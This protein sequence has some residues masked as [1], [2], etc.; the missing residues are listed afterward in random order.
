MGRRNKPWIR[1]QDGQWWTTFRGKKTALRV[2]GE[3]NEAE[4]WKVFHRLLEGILP[5]KQPLRT[6]P[7]PVPKPTSPFVVVN[8]VI[9]ATTLR[10]DDTLPPPVTVRDVIDAYLRDA[11][12]RVK[13]DTLRTYRGFLDP[14]AAKWGHLPAAELTPKHLDA[15]ADGPK[16]W[17]RPWSHDTRRAFKLQVFS[18]Y[19]L[20][21]RTRLL[22]RS[23][24][25]GVKVPGGR[26]RGADAVYTDAEFEKL[27]D[28]AGPH[29]RPLLEFLWLTGCRPGEASRIDA[30]DVV[31]EASV[32][33]V[34]EH[35]TKHKGKTRS[36]PLHPDALSLLRRLAERSPTGPLLRNRDGMPWNK[37]ALVLAMRRCRDR[38]GL[39]TKQMYGIR[40]SFAT[41]ALIDGVENAKVAAILGHSSTVMLSKHYS[42][43]AEQTRALVE[44]V[45][46]VRQ[47]KTPDRGAGVSEGQGDAIPVYVALPQ[48]T[49]PL[50]T[51]ALPPTL[52]DHFTGA[53][54][55][56]GSGG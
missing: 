50:Q 51:W 38:A 52:T 23:P 40:H 18:A 31:W 24:F 54:I 13:P 43:V 46:K 27:C 49:P 30:K 21:V 42:H 5:V 7:R 36:I 17:G 6:R 28:A 8:G 35:K 4:A 26:S 44:A 41:Q 47:R 45:A 29:F 33:V 14:F 9:P 15:Y 2:Y 22:D 20:A 3:E 16:R 56:N 10:C 11:G 12:G 25:A 53:T 39:P 19:L 34:R 1:T 55:G 37:N 32:V 48:P